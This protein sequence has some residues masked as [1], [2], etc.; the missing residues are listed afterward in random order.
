MNHHGQLAKLTQEG[1]V[2]V[3]IEEFRQLQTLVRGWSD[4]A[5]MGTFVDGLK[6]WIANEVKMRQP[7]K[8]QEA[9]KMAKLLE[10]SYY[11]EKKQS[12]TPWK[13]KDAINDTINDK[14]KAIDAGLGKEKKR[15]PKTLTREEVQERV[16]KGL[17][18]KC[19][20]KWG[21]GHK[22]KLEQVY[23]LADDSDNEGHTVLESESEE[24]ELSL[25][26]MTGAC[27]PSTFRL[28]GWIEE[29]EV[30]ILVDT[31]SSHNFINSNTFQRIGLKGDEMGVLHVKVASGEELKCEKMVREVEMHVQGV[32]III[33]LYVL[34]LTGH[35]VVLGI[36]WLK[37][38]GR[39]ITDYSHMTMKFVLWGKKQKWKAIDSKENRSCEANLM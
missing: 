6:P 14:S 1:K 4:N 28:L 33:D 20:D 24:A 12:K 22:C 9:M 31:G 27:T 2:A 13:E 25:H 34:P 16:K 17:C 32:K 30:D 21:I 7:K 5:L 35:D 19:G 18:F 29:H 36:A 8:L 23:V 15:E 11:C 39:V 37:I 3:Y 10:E 26:V 38:V